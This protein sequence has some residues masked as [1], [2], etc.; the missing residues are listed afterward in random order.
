M[1]ANTSTLLIKLEW[2]AIQHV[3]QDGRWPGSVPPNSLATLTAHALLNFHNSS[4]LPRPD[5]ANNS[6][7]PIELCRSGLGRGLLGQRV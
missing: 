1:Q 3:S 4:Y 2:Q 6:A 7:L 5:E